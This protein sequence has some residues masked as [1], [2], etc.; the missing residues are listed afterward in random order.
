MVLI[1]RRVRS[2]RDQKSP[3]H[4][5][6]EAKALFAAWDRTHEEEEAQEGQVIQQG[7][8]RD[9]LKLLTLARIKALKTTK[10]VT[11]CQPRSRVACPMVSHPRTET[12]QLAGITSRG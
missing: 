1:I 10:D 6:H 4:C 2:S 5:G 9:L 3:K 11:P 8:N 7:T 12:A